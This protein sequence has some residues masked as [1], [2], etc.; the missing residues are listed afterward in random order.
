[1]ASFYTM[2]SLCTMACL[3]YLAYQ[4][5]ATI[6]P[7]LLLSAAVSLAYATLTYDGQHSHQQL[8]AAYGLVLPAVVAK[9]AF[10]QPTY[11]SIRNA[12]IDILD[13]VLPSSAVLVSLALLVVWL[14]VSSYMT[15][16]ASSASTQRA[17]SGE[18]LDSCT[19]LTTAPQ[20][21]QQPRSG[22]DCQLSAALPQPMEAT[23][24]SVKPT[25]SSSEIQTPEKTQ[26]QPRM[27][28]KQ[29]GLEFC[30]P[31]GPKPITI[32]K[33]RPRRQATTSSTSNAAPEASV[34]AGSALA[35][36][37]SSGDAP[38]PTAKADISM[39]ST[40]QKARRPNVHSP[41]SDAP[42]KAS[43][44][45][46]SSLA[47]AAAPRDDQKPAVAAG[48]SLPP[49]EPAHRLALPPPSAIIKPQSARVAPTSTPKVTSGSEMQPARLP[50]QRLAL[51]PPSA[52]IRPQ[53]ANAK[54][55]S[56]PKVIVAPEKQQSPV[57][58]QPLALPPLSAI[59]RPQG[60]SVAST[61]M[62]ATRSTS[63]MQPAPSPRPLAS[64]DIVSRPFPAVPDP[65]GG[66]Q[67]AVLPT[68]LLAPVT[69]AEIDSTGMEGVQQEP[70]QTKD[71][72]ME[73]AEPEMKLPSNLTKRTWSSED[74]ALGSYKQE[75]VTSIVRPKKSIRRVGP[76]QQSD[77]QP[78][79]HI[80]DEKGGEP[81]THKKLKAVNATQETES[82]KPISPLLDSKVATEVRLT[83]AANMIKRCSDYFD[84]LVSSNK[85]IVNE[86]FHRVLFDMED[87]IN[88]FIMAREQADKTWRS[89]G[90]P[91]LYH[92][93]CKGKLIGVVENLAML[94]KPLPES[95]KGP[96][97][98]VKDKVA[99][100]RRK[101]L[102]WWME[103]K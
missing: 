80:T 36:A 13:C 26:R 90:N 69:S 1:M 71:H 32:T 10:V 38:P 20:A 96:L 9:D 24:A 59:M 67:G 42:A 88:F 75:N 73:D 83:I 22:E 30:P 43:V 11:Y 51:P 101:M 49:I 31:N 100:L 82:K 3:G 62:P 74:E 89:N 35:V 53:S 54:S 8:N 27:S 5:A 77:D 97:I 91:T 92:D 95:Q 23:Y 103:W 70:P 60:D 78:S 98:N 6:D 102:F 46:G 14:L 34:V 66:T 37:K 7:M 39:P 47:V 48:I 94:A 61:S 81:Q 87:A 50:A 41:R 99:E 29:Y 55:T 45:A 79:G 76:V 33:R 58:A 93:W 12:C 21:E 72:D 84:A 44:F 85:S 40:G 2:F 57:P 18:V 15:M 28:L 19:D 68:S 64:A 25:S 52:M 4:N 65:T 86:T 56:H 17:D 63:E 16:P